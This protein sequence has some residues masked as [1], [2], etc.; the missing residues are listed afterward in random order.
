MKTIVTFFQQ[1]QTG[2]ENPQSTI[3]NCYAAAS[4]LSNDMDALAS[5]V[6]TTGK[7]AMQ[8]RV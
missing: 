6:R 3:Q 2:L 8:V 1:F 4:I 5:Q 7:A